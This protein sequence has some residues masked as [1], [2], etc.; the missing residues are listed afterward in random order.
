MRKCLFLL[1][2]LCGT[3]I[4]L[5]G[6]DTSLVCQPFVSVILDVS[7]NNCQG[8]VS[9]FDLLIGDLSDFSEG[10]FQI[11]IFDDNPVNGGILDG[12]GPFLYEINCLGANV[13]ICENNG[14]CTGQVIGILPDLEITSDASV[15][16]PAG[17]SGNGIPGGTQSCEKVCA[18]STVTYFVALDGFFFIEAV[19]V[20]GSDNFTIF[21]DRVEVTWETPGFGSISITVA[22]SC[23][24][25]Q[26]EFACAEIL[27]NPIAD[28]KTLPEPNGDTLFVC[29]GES[30]Q[31]LN[32]S[33]FAETFFWAFGDGNA[34]EQAQPNHI[35]TQPG[36]YSATL[37]AYNACECT[38]ETRLTVVVEEGE[39]PFVDC[40]GTVCAGQLGTYQATTACNTYA[41]SISGNGT[42]VDGGG[43]Q[44]DFI[45]V[46]WN[47][48]PSG[49]VSL[50]V[51]DCPA[52]SSCSATFEAQVPIISDTI[53]IDGPNNVCRDA[54]EVYGIAP[55]EGTSMTWSTSGL[56]VILEGQGTNEII[57]R[58]ANALSSQPQWVAV[59]LNNCYLGCLTSD[60]LL[61]NITPGLLIEAPLEACAGDTVE[62]EA[63]SIPSGNGASSR[64]VLQNASGDTVSTN[65]VATDTWSLPMDFMDGLY[66]VTATPETG[67]GYCLMSSSALIRVLPTVP[68]VNSIQSPDEICPG[69]VYTFEAGSDLNGARFFWTINDGGSQSTRVG[70]PVNISFGPTPPYQVSV[71]QESV[72]GCSSP[73][74]LITLDT[75]PDLQIIGPDEVCNQEI[76]TYSVADIEHLDYEWSISPAGAGTIINENGSSD[77][78]VSWHHVGFASLTVEACDQIAIMQVSVFGLPEPVVDH[79]D[80]L[81]P[82]ETATVQTTNPF[83]SYLWLDELGNI[84]SSDANP[85]LGPGFYRTVVTDFNGCAEDTVFLIRGHEAPNVSISTPDPNGFCN[86]APSTRLF[87]TDTDAG[88]SF[89]WLQDGMPVGT[90]TDQLTAVDFG[91]YQVSVTDINGC[92][93]LSNVIPVLDCPTGGGAVFPNGPGCVGDIDL[94][95]SGNSDCNDRSYEAIVSANYIPGTAVWNFDDPSS[96]AG[97]ISFGN[98]QT[99]HVFSSPGYYRIMFIGE[100]TDAGTGQPT[101]CFFFRPDTVYAVANFNADTVCA[102]VQTSFTDQSTFIDGA[103]IDS[104]AWDFGDPVS[105]NNTSNLP[106]PQHLYTAPGTYTATL[107]VTSNGCSSSFSRVVT[108]KGLPAVSFPEPTVSCADEAVQFEAISGPDVTELFWSFGDPGSAEA[109][110]AEGTIA[111]HR[112]EVPGTYTVSLIAIGRFGCDST[113]V[114]T[115][116]ILPNN[117]S[118]SIAANGNQFC[119]GDTALL[120]APPG[121]NS[122]IWSTGSVNDSIQVTQTGTFTVTITNS[123]GCTYIPDPVELA[124]RPAPEDTIRAVQYNDS[125]Q[126]V[127]YLYDTLEVCEGTDVFLETLSNPDYSYTWSDGTGAA[128]VEYSDDRGNQLTP[129][130][131]TFDITITDIATGCTNVAGPFIV[132]VNPAPSVQISQSPG[133]FVCEGTLVMFSVDIPDPNLSYRW[134]NGIE[135]PVME[136]DQPGRYTVTATNE[137]GCSAESTA[138][139]IEA[140]PDTS[141]VPS[142]CYSRCR[143]DTLCLPEIPGIALYQWVFDGTPIGTPSPTLPELVATES[144]SYWLDMVANNGCALSSDPLQLELFDG[145][146]QLGGLAYIDVNDNGIIDA[147]DTTFSGAT[148]ELLQNNNLLNSAVATAT[149][150]YSFPNLEGGPYQLNLNTSQL[151]EVLVPVYDQIDTTTFGCF[152]SFPADWLFQIDCV[153]DTTT[154]SLAAC[155]SVVYEGITFI[156][157][158][159]LE[160]QLNSIWGCDSIV[161]I[162]IDILEPTTETLQVSACEGTAFD[163]NGNLIPAGTSDTFTLVNAE[164]CDSLLTVSVANLLPSDSTLN[165]AACQGQSA[166]YLGTPVPAGTQ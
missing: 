80:V 96:G 53:A 76:T 43:P 24:I 42:I 37:T 45:S 105:A 114:E 9:P 104:W 26:Q 33:Q 7:G 77:I 119:A 12:V 65:D 16:C 75:I 22:G 73:D 106:N 112:F 166:D 116:T 99:S 143:P 100:F 25:I 132:I 46:E 151:P 108:V 87:A 17:N 123:N 164:G 66:Q 5:N 6:Q 101:T 64:W 103:N 28:A 57:V 72:F 131:Y 52:T 18:G 32:N 84:V 23:G 34:S 21:S 128:S 102:G 4:N 130:N 141:L 71:R 83:D 134:S 95:I 86:S 109:N 127:A 85:E 155:D 159:V 162:E 35:Y 63:I 144:G 56:G 3:L 148:I 135:G 14:V 121:G 70:N 19:E 124:F 30:V 88:Y 41:W 149:N 92:T 161:I 79:P 110:E 1:V 8:E 154:L 38:D 126:P 146:S 117:L 59:E 54:V 36:T 82:E 93:D 160:N 90:G 165:L 122:W 13:P 113:Y 39:V 142:G 137:F 97:N 68:I 62:I 2:L 91:N 48:G 50:E 157:D 61:V 107:S 152:L 15:I 138:L 69:Q 10:D 27:N 111:Y 125:G 120:V 11:N 98:L 136:T 47:T 31:F 67:S 163:Y 78:I 49:T 51:D 74:T 115:I 44:D 140:G 58:W 40:V 55:F 139:Q 147:A 29:Q 20:S 158:V 94:Q 60:T 153:P 89:Q 129:G 133:G 118:G 81:C 150:G 156:A 145:L